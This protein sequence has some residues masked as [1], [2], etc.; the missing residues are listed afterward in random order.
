MAKDRRGR[1][2]LPLPTVINPAQRRCVTFNVPDDLIH[3]GNFWGIIQKLGLW[4]SYARDDAK[5]GIQ[6]AQVW[7]EVIRDARESWLANEC[8]GEV[9]EGDCTG[10]QNCSGLIT[11]FPQNPCTQPDYIPTGYILPPWFIVDNEIIPI[12]A[13]AKKG[14]V[15]TDLTRLQNPLSPPDPESGGAHLRFTFT[16]PIVQNVTVECH[17]VKVPSFGYA[18]ISQDDNPLNPIAELVDLNRDLASVPP[19]TNIE[20][21][22]ERHFENCSVGTHH[23]DVGVVPYLD[24]EAEIPL[25]YGMCFRGFVLCGKDFSVPVPEMQFT[26]CTI[27]FRPSSTAA[28]QEFNISNCVRTVVGEEIAERLEDGTLGGSQPGAGGNG[29]EPLFCNTY[30]VTLKANQ[31]WLAPIPI[32]ANYR[33]TVSNARGGANGGSVNW[34]CP[35]GEIYGLGQCGGIVQPG[36]TTDPMPT[37]G[38]MRLIMHYNNTFFDAY[39][40][41]HDVSS[42]LSGSH[43][44]QFQVNDGVLSDN[45]GD[46][47]FD[48][49]IC[50][51][52]TVGLHYDSA[53]GQDVVITQLETHKWHVNVQGAQ[54]GL[55][56][57]PYVV[58]LWFGEPL[59]TPTNL[60]ARWE[61]TN[62]VG[63][64]GE[65]DPEHLDAKCYRQTCANVLQFSPDQQPLTT[66]ADGLCL[67]QVFGRSKTA[68]SF[69]VELFFDCE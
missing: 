23:V 66:W 22:I 10:Y 55:T 12:A 28:W 63:W 58:T 4:Q 29:P 62:Q 54:P 25:H 61:F 30:H 14:D 49:E 46:Y 34:Y 17:F 37:N 1:S 21:V 44:L 7:Q 8:G 16:N 53:S 52:P 11:W 9:E 6:V 36:E 33:I 32:K 19:E 27:R 56:F 69:D 5:T 41:E 15:W 47:Q 59:P 65:T 18:L 38:H 35:S 31:K 50:N 26:D 20:T 3:I 13:G 24:N 42:G 57:A 43:D 40:V 60:C 2:L 45:S 51:Q 68:Y 67:N 48:L 39:N 64:S